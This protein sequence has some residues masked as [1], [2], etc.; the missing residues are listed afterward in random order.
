MVMFLTISTT[1]LTLNTL[2][3]FALINYH[4]YTTARSTDPD[5]THTDPTLTIERS[6]ISVTTDSSLPTS[7][8]SLAATQPKPSILTP[9][10]Q[11]FKQI[12]IQPPFIVNNNPQPQPTET[13][14]IYLQTFNHS[15]PQGASP[16]L[17]PLAVILILCSILGFISVLLTLPFNLPGMSS[18]SSSSKQP[19]SSSSPKP[20]SSSS[21]SSKPSSSSSSSS[22]SSRPSSSSSSGSPMASPPQP[23]PTISANAWMS[24]FLF[25]CLVLIILQGPLG[26]TGNSILPGFPSTFIGGYKSIPNVLPNIGNTLPGCIGIVS[27]YVPW[28]QQEQQP[29]IQVQQLIQNPSI[30]YDGNRVLYG[31]GIPQGL[32]MGGQGGFSSSNGGGN[33]NW[34]SNGGGGGNIVR[35]P[36]YHSPQQQQ[37]SVQYQRPGLQIQINQGRNPVSQQG[38]NDNVNV[39]SQYINQPPPS[40]NIPIQQPISIN[41]PPSIIPTSTI[42]SIN[43]L[44]NAFYPL[45]VGAIA[46]LVVFDYAS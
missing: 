41:N 14:V 42:A 22:S 23:I 5:I 13:Q 4:T 1:K 43:N 39:Q 21:S 9:P 20:S 6:S 37:R 29:Q 44:E 16:F 7:Q 34:Y 26:L 12:P 15:L 19:S 33:W 3:I 35:Q 2:V 27:G 25:C 32:N 11:Q 17:H 40:Q 36:I 46:L 38:I 45:L 31:S 24:F 10:Q 8:D 28:C 18:S 30:N